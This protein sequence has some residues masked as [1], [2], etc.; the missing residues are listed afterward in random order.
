MTSRRL[1]WALVL[2]A[3][4]G[5][6]AFG[7]SRALAP[8]QPHTPAAVT[9]QVAAS[10]RCPTCQGLSVADSPSQLAE[11][12]RRTIHDQAQAGRSP[13]QIRAYFVAR[14]G[15]WILLSPPRHGLGWLVWALPMVVLVAGSTLA[16]RFA[17]RR[18]TLPTAS[19]DELTQAHTAYADHVERRLVPDDSPTG[20]RLAAALELLSSVRDDAARDDRHPQAET[21]A[22]HRLAAALADHRNAA[23]TD[24]DHTDGTDTPGGQAT[25]AATAPSTDRR[26]VRP[27]TYVGIGTVLGAVLALLLVTNLGGRGA[28]G[29]PTGLLAGDDPPPS[30][31]TSLQT[32]QQVTREHPRDP[33]AW[34]ALGR[35]HDN[36]GTLSKAYRAY[37]KALRLDPRDV[38]ARQLTA[39]TLIRGGSPTQALPQLEPLA[40][41]RPDDPRTV[42]LLGLARYGTD[43]PDAIATL[44]AY[45]DLRPDGPIAEQVRRL[46]ERSQR[47]QPRRQRSG[48][49]T[50]P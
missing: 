42:L 16:W 48:G 5:L 19:S 31:G 4:L 39:W 1:A 46:I 30:A 22:L 7:L 34:L 12:I 23:T 32:L 27:M 17:R 13:D 50:S 10:L 33:R 29:L 20:Q 11:G 45:L 44:R 9:Q 21:E 18:A 43:H 3:A 6:A 24:D 49:P 25:P 35:A 2:V 41:R 26:R 37:R 40:Q 36:Q 15:E 28:D 47:K 14:Y 8:E 38:Q